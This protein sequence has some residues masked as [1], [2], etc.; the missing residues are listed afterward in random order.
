MVKKE[1]DDQYFE[2]FAKKLD[3]D[4]D[5]WMWTNNAKKIKH[6][7]I[8]IHVCVNEFVGKIF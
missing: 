4:N 6:Y 7:H 2:Y 8:H 5:I 3:L 1:N